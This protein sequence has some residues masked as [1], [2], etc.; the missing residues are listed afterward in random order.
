MS[1]EQ[2]DDE[3]VTMRT[4]TFAVRRT[5]TGADHVHGCGAT[6]KCLG[7]S[8]RA[9]GPVSVMPTMTMVDAHRTDRDDDVHPEVQEAPDEYVRCLPDAQRADATID[10]SAAAEHPTS[11]ADAKREAERA[12]DER[13]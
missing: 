11:L 5:D 3:I 1:H 8:I 13:Q 6:K 4:T 10:L 12:Y 9:I 7:R 2:I